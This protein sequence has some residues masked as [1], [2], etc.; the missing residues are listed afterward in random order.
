M[1]HALNPVVQQRRLRAELRRARDQAG[2]TQ[3]DVADALEWS[4]SKIIRIEA[5]AVS[6]SVT[7]LKAL[8]DHYKVSDKD[9]VERLLAMSRASKQRSW[10]DKYKQ[11]LNPDFS[12]F[13]GLEAS[14]SEVRQF[15]IQVIP[16]LLQ[17]A[18]YA[19][20]VFA[21]YETDPRISQSRIEVRMERQKLL[22]QKN[23]PQFHF[24]LDESTLHRRIGDSAV[25]REQLLHLKEVSKLPH[26]DIR[27]L[28]FDAGVTKGMQSSF[29]VLDFHPD[30]HDY[31]D[32]VVQLEQVVRDIL[33][34]NDPTTASEYVEHFM[35]LESL[36]LTDEGL[37]ATIDRLLAKLPD[38]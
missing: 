2:L 8:L 29:V 30:D 1:T 18:K 7:D 16:G 26:V 35:T 5:G 9:K 32:Q 36:S 22:T 37:N 10:W 12:Q 13:L 27:V 14:A 20:A 24:V 15:Q 21:S 19:Q 31:I 28:P 38:S 23:G 6:I 34:E 17:T 3:R 25:M 4:P 11:H 33:I